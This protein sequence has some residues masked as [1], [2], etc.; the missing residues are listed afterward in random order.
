MDKDDPEDNCIFPGKM[1]GLNVVSLRGRNAWDD[2]YF[3]L[4]LRE[5]A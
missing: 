2:G 1:H 5:A 4:R 3:S